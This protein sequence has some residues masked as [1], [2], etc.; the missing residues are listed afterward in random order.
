MA[1]KYLKWLKKEQAECKRPN[2]KNGRSAAGDRVGRSVGASVRMGKALKIYLFI[3]IFFFITTG[4]VL[5]RL[6]LPI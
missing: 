3:Y 4:N 2:S 6:N 1:K 5:G